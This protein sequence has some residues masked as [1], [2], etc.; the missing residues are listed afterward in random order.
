MVPFSFFL[1][2]EL[3]S[4]PVS[5][6][7]K[8]KNPHKKTHKKPLFFVPG[9]SMLVSEP[10]LTENN[11]SKLRQRLQTVRTDLL[12][13]LDQPL[14][15]QLGFAR[16]CIS[17]L[18]AAEVVE[19]VQGLQD[20]VEQ[21]KESQE[22]GGKRCNPEDMCPRVLKL[23]AGALAASHETLTS[24]CKARVEELQKTVCEVS[25]T[26]PFAWRSCV[27]VLWDLS[28][29]ALQCRVQSACLSPRDH[30][31]GGPKDEFGRCNCRGEDPRCLSGPGDGG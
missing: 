19:V 30:R 11:L 26:P 17:S 16:N 14:D 15:V 24:I 23:G 25:S 7:K 27:M 4:L 22:D 10:V 31:E 6:Q 20:C 5:P 3:S 28:F 18:Q 8:K 9:E 29:T 2:D 1:V 21:L 13:S 12:D